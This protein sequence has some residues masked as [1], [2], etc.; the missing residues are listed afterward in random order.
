MATASGVKRAERSLWWRGF[1]GRR[2]AEDLGGFRR[3]RVGLLR[4]GCHRQGEVRQH[5]G[6]R[7]QGFVPVRRGRSRRQGGRTPAPAVGECSVS[8]KPPRRK[9]WRSSRTFKEDSIGPDGAPTGLVSG[10]GGSRLPRF[11]RARCHNS[12]RYP[13]QPTEELGLLV[14]EKLLRNVSGGGCCRCAG[15]SFAAE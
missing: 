14:A 13:P 3:N 15:A 11:A 8:P 12:V 2:H 7:G 4:P 5:H 10:A 1:Q 9:L 6:G